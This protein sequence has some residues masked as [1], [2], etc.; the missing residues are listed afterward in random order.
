M[1]EPWFPVDLFVVCFTPVAASL[2]AIGHWRAGQSLNA[3]RWLAG[4]WLAMAG[5]GV[6]ACVAG[7]PFA[8]WV[9]PLGLAACSASLQFSRLAGFRRLLDLALR[10]LSRP[11]LQAA[12]LMIAGGGAALWWA[13]RIDPG[14]QDIAQFTGSPDDAHAKAHLIAVEPSPARTDLGRPVALSHCPSAGPTSGQPAPE[15]AERLHRWGLDAQLIRTAASDASHNCHGWTFAGG[16]YWIDAG[17][18]EHILTDNGYQVAAEPRPGDLAIYRETDGH[19]LHSGIVEAVTAPGLVLV[20]S[21][22]G[23]MGRYLHPADRTRYNGRLLYYHSSRQGHLLR[24]L[25][26]DPTRHAEILPTEKASNPHLR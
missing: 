18:V 24:G 1:T 10:S 25:D 8:M 17:E 21:K 4:G 11:G 14:S 6:A 23:E 22:W 20:E 2:L 9:P 7:Q 19:I 26:G 13:E 16:H 12:V 3:L 5:F 15:D